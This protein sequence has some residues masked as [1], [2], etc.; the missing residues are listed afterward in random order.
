MM[1]A[2]DRQLGGLGWF[3]NHGRRLVAEA[4]IA[5]AW[6]NPVAWLHEA[7]V[8][9]EE[10]DQ[11]RLASACRS[12]LRKAGAPPRNRRRPPVAPCSRGNRP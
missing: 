8:F 4:A 11:D 12:L 5:D 10:C 3:R 9:F 6:G 2:G 1:L 7:L